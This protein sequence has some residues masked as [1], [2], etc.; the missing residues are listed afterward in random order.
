EVKPGREPPSLTAEGIVGAV[1]GVLHARLLER[2]PRPMVEL[3][4]PLMATIVLPYLGQ[5]AARKELARPT[6]E[7]RPALPRPARYPLDDLHMR[8]TYRTLRVLAAVAA[9]SGES[10]R[11]I[12]DHAGISDPGQ[13]S[14]LLARLQSHGLVQNVARAQ[15]KGERNAWTL[16][17]KGERVERATRG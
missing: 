15:G 12:A 8:I 4:N 3:L 13:I 2:D 16:T 6:P 7:A 17:E 1:L 14:K 5:T 10:N 9:L 11:E